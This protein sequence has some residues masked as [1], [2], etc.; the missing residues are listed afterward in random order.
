M[1]ML[2]KPY[3]DLETAFVYGA[4]PRNGLTEAAGI[5]TA[6]PLGER[7]VWCTQVE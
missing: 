7:N 5:R 3:F 4:H 6:F 2:V 1:G